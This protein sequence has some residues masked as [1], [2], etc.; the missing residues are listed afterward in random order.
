MTSSDPASL[1]NLNDIV[2]PSS[3]PWW[4][5]ANGWY[6]LIALLMLALGWAVYR[7]I[8]KRIANRYRRAA[9]LDLQVLGRGIS[10]PAEKDS[11]LRQIPALLKRTALS[12][13]PRTLVAGLSGEN[14]LRF[15]NSTADPSPFTPGTFQTLNEISYTTGELTDIDEQRA[16]ELLGAC[17]QWLKSHRATIS[18]EQ[19]GES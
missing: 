19:A 8:R 3:V 17:E 13:Y 6:V 10:T 16:N 12:V 1:Q 11:C 9:L 7:F 15:L 4:P 5:L 2:M 18:P 14:W